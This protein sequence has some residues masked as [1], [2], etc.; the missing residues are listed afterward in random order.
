MQEKPTYTDFHKDTEKIKYV[1]KWMVKEYAWSETMDLKQEVIGPWKGI[2]AKFSNQ[3][4][5]IIWRGYYKVH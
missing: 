4:R 2:T 5:D 3:F 1:M